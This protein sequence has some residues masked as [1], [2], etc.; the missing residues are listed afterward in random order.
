MKPRR[1]L[2]AASRHVRSPR[3]TQDGGGGH[4]G[5]ALRPSF[6]PLFTGVRGIGILRSSHRGHALRPSFMPLFTGVRGIGIL[7]SSQRKV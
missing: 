4:R 5:H 2:P 6:M 3:G 1:A 7:R